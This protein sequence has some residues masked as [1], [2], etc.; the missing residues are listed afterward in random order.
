M[1]SIHEQSYGLSVVLHNEFTLGDFRQLEEALLKAIEQV[2]FPNLLL[3]MSQ[4]KDFTVD[5]ALEHLRFLRQHAHDFGRT[6]I[7][8]DDIWIRLGARFANLLTLQRPKYFNDK[9]TAQKW[10][11]QNVQN[12][13]VIGSNN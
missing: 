5:M 4:M 11:E 13:G 10:L 3:D 1:I 2:Q 7:I 6:A 9:H 8:V 12:S